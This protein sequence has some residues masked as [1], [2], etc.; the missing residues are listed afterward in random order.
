L[1]IATEIK[2]QS[3]QNN[4]AEANTNRMTEGAIYTCYASAQNV[5]ET[6]SQ[7]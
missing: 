6:R 4:E 1:N 5:L 3:W 7:I 2:T